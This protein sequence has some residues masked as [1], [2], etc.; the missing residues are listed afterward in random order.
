M[1]NAAPGNAAAGG[2]LANWGAT[3]AAAGAAG[4]GHGCE[5]GIAEYLALS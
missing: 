2:I 5:P 3:A 4:G 1:T